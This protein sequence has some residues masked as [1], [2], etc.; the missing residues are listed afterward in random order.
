MTVPMAQT[1]VVAAVAL[2]DDAGRMLTV[3][4]RGTTRFMNPG[5]KPEP[6]ETPVQAAVREIEEELGVRL[7]P[8]GVHEL[9]VW[10]AAAANEPGATVRAYAFRA[11]LPAG[12]TPQPR[13]EIAELRWA[14]RA[15]AL[16]APQ[17]FAPLLVER[18]VPVLGDA[19]W[20]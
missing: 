18:F 6:G 13:A 9:G 19:P 16:A 15:E 8:A 7:D 12:A 3:R 5:G 14:T 17:E 20:G 4:K 1:I 11:L 2:L 10:S